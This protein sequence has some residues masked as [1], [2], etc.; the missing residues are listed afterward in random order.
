MRVFESIQTLLDGFVR[1]KL[2]V[3]ASALVMKDGREAFFGHA[4]L[5]D[6]S[7]P[8]DGDTVMLMYSMTKVVTAAAVMKLTEE[9]ALSPQ[10]PVR[11]L[12]PAFGQT[13]VMRPD[14]TQEALKRQLTVHDLLSMTS[15]IPYPGGN[16][17]VSA[18]Y[19]R[20]MA[21]LRQPEKMTTLDL[22][23]YIAQCPLC[24]QPGKRWLYGLSADVLGGVISAVTGLTPEAYM[25]RTIFDPLGMRDTFFHVPAEKRG[26]LAA[27][28]DADG[29]GGFTIR[30]ARFGSGTPDGAGIE[31]C[32]A[33]LYSTLGDFARFGEMLRLDG[34]GVLS[35]ASVRRMTGNQLSPA[36]LTSFGESKSGYGYG[37]LVR[38]LMDAGRNAQY[39]EAVGSFGWNGMGGTTLRVDPARGLTVVFGM[40]R[41]PPAHDL[42]LPPL[43]QAVAAADSRG[44]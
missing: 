33:G 1:Q 25:R 9:G 17:A 11:E 37:Y 19:G 35:P 32:G 12:I 3:G 14:G 4:G 40:Q 6:A 43:M 30:A 21:S 42:F 13:R 7:A 18:C 36:Q 15:G 31:M 38:T 24:F 16:D 22:A 26:R 29:S 39:R 34:A 23:A 8:F 5:R 44:A 27:V 10:T 2:A 41:V 28:Y 20:V